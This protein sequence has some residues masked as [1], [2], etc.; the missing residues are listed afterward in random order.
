MEDHEVGDEDLVH[1]PPRLEAVQV[2]LSRLRLD[3]AGLVGQVGAGG[4]DQLASRLEHLGDW[5]LRQPL[6]LK[7]GVEFPQLIGN[8]DVALRVPKADR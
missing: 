1:P 3:V 7:V 8:R 4:M 2:V 6:D 5:V